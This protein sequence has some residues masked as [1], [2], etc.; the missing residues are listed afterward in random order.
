MQFSTVVTRLWLVDESSKANI[1]HMLC[2]PAVC[3]RL[4]C[5]RI[6]QIDEVP[7]TTYALAKTSRSERPIDQHPE[8]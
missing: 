3:D 6:E 1:M 7:Q 2:H 8:S 4:K 5:R